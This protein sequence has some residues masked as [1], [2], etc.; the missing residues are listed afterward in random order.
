MLK[1]FNLKEIPTR[2]LKMVSLGSITL[3]M[4]INIFSVSTLA[5]SNNNSNNTLKDKDLQEISTIGLDL[6]SGDNN[7]ISK[8]RSKIKDLINEAGGKDKAL[9][10][11]KVFL[12]GGNQETFKQLDKGTQKAILASYQDIIFEETNSIDIDT[13]QRGL[14]KQERN[15]TYCSTLTTTRRA[16]SGIFS[17]LL[18][19]YKQFVYR[20]YNGS[21]VFNVS[22]WVEARLVDPLWRFNGNVNQYQQGGNYQSYFT[23]YTMGSFTCDAFFKGSCGGLNPWI[24][25]TVR[26]TGSY[27][28][29]TGGT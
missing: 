19:E 3:L 17:V 15:Y 16:Y 26:N 18:F 21:Q 4:L 6:K 11:Y 22:R 20:C 2:T 5:Y 1:K 27:S 7:K 10:S 28:T 25:Q 12:A 9:K 14:G 8:A 29:E 23:A 13:A 24:K